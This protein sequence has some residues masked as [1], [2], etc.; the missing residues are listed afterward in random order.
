MPISKEKQPKPV[1]INRRF[2]TTAT[3]H[4]PSPLSSEF[5]A[6]RPHHHVYKSE[7]RFLPR[8]RET[9]GEKTRMFLKK[10]AVVTATDDRTN[11]VCPRTARRL[12]SF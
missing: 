12:A 10:D 7:R 5:G 8:H 1:E 9:W 3:T 2:Q 6:N 4:A 11:H